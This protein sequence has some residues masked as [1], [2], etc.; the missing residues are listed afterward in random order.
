MDLNPLWDQ[1]QYQTMIFSSQQ[2]SKII[3]TRLVLNPYTTA[4]DQE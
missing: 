3:T 2:V 1:N 4:Q